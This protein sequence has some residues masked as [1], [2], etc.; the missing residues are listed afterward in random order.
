MKQILNI[1]HYEMMHILR[2]RLLFLIVF[3]VPL[4]YAALF[5]TVYI[6][7]T[8]QNVPLAIV[9]LDNSTQSRDVVTAFSNAPNFRV[10]PGIN[11]Y[12]D[13]EQGMRNGTVRAG[14]VIPE[15]YSQKL[16]QHQLT[17]LLVVYDGSNLIYGFNTRRYLQ[18]VFNSLSAEHAASYLAGLGMTEGEINA[19][20]DAVSFSTQVWYNPTFSYTSYIFM[21]LVVMILHQIGLL[22]VGLTVT[23]EKE[24]N[25]WL[26][27]LSS[28][29]SPWKIFAG[30]ALPYF[31]ANFFNYALLLW[32][33]ARFVNVKIEGSVALMLLLGLLFN[34]LIVSLGFVV[35]LYAPNSLQ[36]TRYIML[37]SVPLF[38]L[39]GYT[40]PG[41]HIPE[42]INGLG[43]LLPYTWMTQ[44]MRL[45]TV[46]NL[47]WDYLGVTFLALAIMAGITTWLAV[48]FSKRRKPLVPD[49]LS[50]NGGNAYPNRHS[51]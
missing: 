14:V 46:K 49:G 32:V 3:A 43:K 39:S 21:G 9:D 16:S 30:K 19:T 23:R 11:S 37:L 45:V 50:V 2:D 1:A 6:S 28:A 48:T 42:A 10:V 27:F 38:V 24:K 51:Y 13:L 36:V 5:G 41:T 25:S 4:F 22:G 44:G 31:V 34:L 15:D 17:Q 18:T 26:Q 40:W 7:G 47:G 8:L 35:S 33:S 29:V 12:A 20:L